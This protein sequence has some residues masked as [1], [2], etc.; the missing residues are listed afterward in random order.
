MSP[1]WW[2]FGTFFFEKKFLT[3]NAS[4]LL[5]DKKV[6]FVYYSIRKLS[7][8]AAAV[9]FKKR[10]R[11]NSNVF[12][13][14]CYDCSSSSVRRKPATWSSTTSWSPPTSRRS[15]NSMTPRPPAWSGSRTN[16]LWRSWFRLWSSPWLLKSRWKVE[17]QTLWLSER[18]WW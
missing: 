17:L 14:F 6:C 13:F 15:T 16:C 11:M 3:A 10:Q 18:S 12:F 2:I 4:L 8:L 5:N 9:A 7:A 1:F